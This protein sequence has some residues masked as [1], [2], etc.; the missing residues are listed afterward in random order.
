M[1]VSSTIVLS[2]DNDTLSVINYN[3]FEEKIKVYPKVTDDGGEKDQLIAIFGGVSVN[4]L[5]NQEYSI[6][7]DSLLDGLSDGLTVI[8]LGSVFFE[9]SDCEKIEIINNDGVV[10]RTITGMLGIMPE[11]IKPFLKMAS[12]VK[13]SGFNQFVNLNGT[14][15]PLELSF[16]LE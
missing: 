8:H 11:E 3:T 9:K 12:K 7:R 5:D 14:S 2:Q 1:L 10:V 13:I 4:L 15:V 16:N 6:N